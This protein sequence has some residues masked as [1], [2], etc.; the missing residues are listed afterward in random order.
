MSDVPGIDVP[1]VTAW[2]QAHVSGAHAPFTF[3]VIAGGHS[4]LTFAVTGAD[5]SRYVL[6]RPP[7]GHVLASAHDMG[8][9]H[10]IIS[11]LQDSRVPVA[12]ALGYCDDPAVNGVPFYVMGFVDGHVIRDGATA[13]AV[14]SPDARRHASESIVD[15]MAAIH[16]V[17]LGDAG[18]DDLGKHDGYIARQLKRWYSNWN[19][20]KT[21]EL[22]A[23][24]LVHDGLLQRIPAQG[25]ATIVHGDYR[26]DNCMVNDHGDVI[27]VLDWEICTLG[28]PLAD[29][30]LL[31]VYWTGPGDDASAW[32]GSSTSSPGFLDRADLAERYGRITGRDLSQLD[33]YIAFAYWKLAC[34]LE[35]VYSRYLGGALGDRDP[36]ELLPFKLQV[37]GAAAKA[38]EALERLA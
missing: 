9:E 22:P 14:L 4:N 21:R 3:T 37:D 12:P 30:G 15:T 24:D 26:L 19:S 1:S 35:G 28:D 8:R 29:L 2:L 38:A 31:M 13:M 11:G 5:G 23:V 25:P 20:Q 36:A 32:T 6:R 34:I 16:A 7:L 10:R 18:L 33:F 27:A 17:D